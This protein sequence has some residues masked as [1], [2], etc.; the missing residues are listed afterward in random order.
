MANEPKT[1][2]ADINETQMLLSYGESVCLNLLKDH[3]TQQN[4][5]WATD[6]YADTLGEGY[7]FFDPKI[8]RAHV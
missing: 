5:Y 2:K 4:I 6:S 1:S 3:T 7:K 8:G